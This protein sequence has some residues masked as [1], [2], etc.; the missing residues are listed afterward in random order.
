MELGEYLNEFLI[1]TKVKCWDE[2]EQGL[3]LAGSLTGPVDG[4]LR[5]E[6]QCLKIK[7]QQRFELA[8]REEAF[9]AELRARQG[10]RSETTLSLHIPQIVGV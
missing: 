7:L 1:V 3:Y 2:E 8:C 5:E 4:L 6:C 10:S 9:W